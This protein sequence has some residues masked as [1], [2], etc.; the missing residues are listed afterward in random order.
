MAQ[1]VDP[2][3]RVRAGLGEGPVW[4]AAHGR[5]IWIDI[6]LN[7]LYFTQVDTGKTTHRDLPGSPGCAALTRDG[8]IVVAIGQALVRLTDGGGTRT[9]AALPPGNAGRFNDGKPDAAGRLWVGTAT[10]DGSFDCALWRFDP[11]QGFARQVT[12]VSM[13]N[14]LGWSRDGRRMYYVDSLTHRVDVLDHDPRAGRLSGRR[15]LAHVPEDQLPD[16]LCVDAEGGIWLA[17]WG[18]GCVLHL[19]PD[20]KV[21]GRVD[22]PTPL[23]T[24]CAFG[25]RDLKTLYITTARENDDDRAAGRLFAAD[26]GAAGAPPGRI[27]ID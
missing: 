26:V 19:S 10:A 25:G 7:R 2:V 4:D 27:G 1:T 8:D 13:S 11:V 23:V 12:A 18:G 9:I 14:G 3:G 20:G 16:G 21:V 5:L 17:V 24:S 6:R 22:L 15:P